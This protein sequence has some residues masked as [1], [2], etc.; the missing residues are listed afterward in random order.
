LHSL[1]IFYLFGDEQHDAF[2]ELVAVEGGDGEIEE[3]AVE[4]RTWNELQL[5][6]EQDRQTDQHVRQ[7]SSD[8]GLAHTHDPNTEKHSPLNH[9]L[10]GSTSCYISHWKWQILTP[11][12]SKT[13]QPILTKFET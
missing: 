10:Y 8:A 9:G 4:N 5:L 7:D 13:V 12:I 3:E 1:S 11:Q 6:D 2:K